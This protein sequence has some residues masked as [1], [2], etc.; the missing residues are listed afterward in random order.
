MSN[1]MKLMAVVQRISQSFCTVLGRSTGHEGLV[2]R[3]GN[4]S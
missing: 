1:S 4:G 3:V 2:C